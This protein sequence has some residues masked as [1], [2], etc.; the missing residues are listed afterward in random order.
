MTD[1]H[2]AAGDWAAAQHC[3]H[4]LLERAGAIEERTWRALAAEAC[5]RVALVRGNTTLARSFL[6]RAWSDIDGYDTPM[7]RWRLHS[8]QAA[9]SEALGDLHSAAR[10]RGFQANE[11]AALAA[12]LPAGHSGRDTLRSAQPLIPELNE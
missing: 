11:L 3:A 2:L 8:V 12:T 1:A 9:L 4:Q 7:A 5:A 10:H 6:A